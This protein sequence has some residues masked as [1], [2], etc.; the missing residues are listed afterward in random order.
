MRVARIVVGKGKT[1][2]PSEAEEWSKVYFEIEVAIADDKEVPLAKE[3]AESL[4]NSWL[5][6][7][8]VGFEPTSMPEFDPDILFQHE[9]KGRRKADGSYAKGSLE[10]GWDFKD[11]FP[12]NVIKV[13]KKGPL[14]IDQYEFSLSDTGNLVYAR[15]KRAGGF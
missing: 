3:W 13:L 12:E 4:I 5:E 11:N 1:E 9:W 2:R 15:K 14:T 6:E 8:H 7:K 10:W